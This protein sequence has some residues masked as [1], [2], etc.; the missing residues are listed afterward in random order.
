MRCGIAPLFDG[1][2]RR[3][4]IHAWRGCSHPKRGTCHPRRGRI[5]ARRACPHAR[6]AWGH[7]RRAPCH[8]R[9]ATPHARRGCPHAWRA[10]T[11]ASDGC[12]HAWRETSHAERAPCHARADAGSG[13]YGSN[14]R[15]AG[16]EEPSRRKRGRHLRTPSDIELSVH[17][18]ERLLDGLACDP[19]LQRDLNVISTVCREARDLKLARSERIAKALVSRDTGRGRSLP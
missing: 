13:H 14:R 18:P 7:R 17:A 3:A 4:C 2:P 12:I 11:H 9:R 5:H 6:R 19:E 15:L 1:H 10:P 16:T 8:A